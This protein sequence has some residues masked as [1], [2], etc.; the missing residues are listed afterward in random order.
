MCNNSKEWLD[1]T[2]LFKQILSIYLYCVLFCFP[3]PLGI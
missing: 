3:I 1:A 2:P